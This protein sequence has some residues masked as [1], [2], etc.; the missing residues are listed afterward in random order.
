M[1][2]DICVLMS[3]YN[4]EKYIEQQIESILEQKNVNVFIYV[5]DDGS[6][7]R[8]VEILRCYEKRGLLKFFV[9]N[10]IGPAKSFIELVYNAPSSSYYAFSDQDDIWLDNK[11]YEGVKK[12]FG[13][14]ESPAMYNSK[15]TVV[16]SDL[17]EIGYYGTNKVY[18]FVT[19]VAR[20]NVIGCTMII[21]R[22]LAEKIKQY[23]PTYVTMHD[24]WI[25]IV[26]KGLEG[27]EIKDT[28][29]YILYRQ[30]ENNTVGAE[31]NL[32]KRIRK[33]SLTSTEN[34]R[35]KQI[36][37][38]KNGFYEELSC[39]KKVYLDTIISYKNNFECLLKCIFL[40][41][42]TE[43]KLFD[44]LIKVSIVRKKF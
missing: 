18:N 26:C 30:H 13:Y 42:K 32:L 5:R 43:R 14:D 41:Y 15:V 31:R 8:T 40:P 34:T 38:F 19:Q 25:A 27:I 6:T 20:S 28:K 3:T 29:S 36:Q 11:L 9:G 7:D 16:D 12:L 35:L 17:N 2:C 4:G 33:S 1:K 44:W 37:E 39:E 23:K 21:N 10:N 24:Q 22:L